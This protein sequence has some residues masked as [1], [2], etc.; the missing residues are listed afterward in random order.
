MIRGVSKGS[1]SRLAM[2]ARVPSRQATA[3]ALPSSVRESTTTVP[4]AASPTCTPGSA[5]HRARP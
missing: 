1:A 4:P 2:A 3:A 5:L